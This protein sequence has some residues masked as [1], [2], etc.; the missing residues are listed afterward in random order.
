MLELILFYWMISNYGEENYKKY[1]KIRCKIISR[2]RIY[3]KIYI[4]EKIIKRIKV[5]L[6]WYLFGIFNKIKILFFLKRYEIRE[7]NRL[8]WKYFK[9]I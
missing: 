9:E 2:N 5:N 3:I 6:W 8:E 4:L 7:N 1:E